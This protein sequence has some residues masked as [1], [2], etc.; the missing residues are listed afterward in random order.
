MFKGAIPWHEH[1]PT[2]HLQNFSIIPKGFNSSPV[3]LAASPWEPLFYL[4]SL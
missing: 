2:I 3:L 1:I 4:M